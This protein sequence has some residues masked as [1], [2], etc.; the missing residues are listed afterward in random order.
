VTAPGINNIDFT[1]M[2]TTLLT[3]KKK[4]EFRAEFFNLFNHA[5]FGLPSRTIFN[6]SR[7]HSGNEGAITTTAKDNRIFS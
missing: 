2:K 4:L 6:S 5:N 7:V 3:E 1:V